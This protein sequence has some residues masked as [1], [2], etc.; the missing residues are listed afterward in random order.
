[1]SHAEN[2]KEKRSLWIKFL[3]AF[4]MALL[5]SPIALTASPTY[6][7]GNGGGKTSRLIFGNGGGFIDKPDS[8]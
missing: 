8:I 4:V 7:D 2:R 3:G 1:M 5:L 6:L